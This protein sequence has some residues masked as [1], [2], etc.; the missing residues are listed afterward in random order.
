[1]ID[2]SLD[3]VVKR[4]E[5]PGDHQRRSGHGKLTLAMGITRAENGADMT[6]GSLVVRRLR[7]EPEIE[8]EVTPRIG[9]TKCAE[10]PLRYLI[11]G[12][13]FVS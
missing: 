6:R 13:P 9:I 2:A 8:I 10:L 11:A 7:S 12:N 1:M 3:S 5:E 4:M